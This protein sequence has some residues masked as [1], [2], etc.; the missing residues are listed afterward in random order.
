MLTIFSGCNFHPKRFLIYNL[1]IPDYLEKN[2]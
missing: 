2:L 1:V